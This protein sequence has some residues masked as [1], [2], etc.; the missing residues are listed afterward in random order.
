MM[1][2]ILLVSFAVV[3]IAATLRSVLR[4]GYRRVPRRAASTLEA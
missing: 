2:L 3:A 1:L 4:D